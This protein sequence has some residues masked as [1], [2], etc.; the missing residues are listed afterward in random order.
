VAL[1][2]PGI[3]ATQMWLLFCVALKDERV[4]FLDVMNLIRAWWLAI[5]RLPATRHPLC[6]ACWCWAAVLTAFFLVGGMDYWMPSK[7]KTFKSK[8][9]AFVKA[10][11][12]LRFEEPP[13]D[14][15]EDDSE[16]APPPPQEVDPDSRPTITC[17]IIG[18]LTNPE[19][20]G[21]N[22]IM[23]AIKKD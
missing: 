15:D 22:G 5:A 8:A 21:L 10:I 4:E 17:T 11:A 2:I 9:K 13:D 1:A 23:L 16:P 12:D 7:H 14:D 18:Y 20:G 19:E 6:S 3:L